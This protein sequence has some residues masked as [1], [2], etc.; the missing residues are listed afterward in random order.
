MGVMSNG[1]TNMRFEFE[2]LE[3]RPANFLILNLLLVPHEE[4]GHGRDKPPG[5]GVLVLKS[6][7]YVAHQCPPGALGV[8]VGVELGD[9]TGTPQPLPG[10]EA[11]VVGEYRQQALPLRP[12]PRSLASSDACLLKPGQQQAHAAAEPGDLLQLLFALI[13]GPPERSVTVQ[14]HRVHADLT[15]RPT[16]D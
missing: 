11:A 14:P 16:S 4:A 13:D 15:N 1:R 2:W 3:Y 12:G 6:P 7:P 8:Q 5:G 9:L 10:Q